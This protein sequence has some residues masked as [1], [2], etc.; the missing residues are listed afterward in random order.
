MTLEERYAKQRELL[1]AR[2]NTK[3]LVELIDELTDDETIEVYWR[4][5]LSKFPRSFVNLIIGFLCFIT[6]HTPLLSSK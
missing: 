1:T 4:F 3:V 5:R 2:H 6:K